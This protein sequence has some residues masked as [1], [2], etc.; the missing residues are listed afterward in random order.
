MTDA[1]CFFIAIICFF[2]LVFVVIIADL[3]ETISFNVKCIKEVTDPFPVKSTANRWHRDEDLQPQR[4]HGIRMITSDDCI[5]K[6]AKRGRAK[7][8]IKK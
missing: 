2:I 6:P 7:R 4:I 1:A 5:V 3:L 8:R